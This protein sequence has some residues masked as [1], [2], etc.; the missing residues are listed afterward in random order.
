[1]KK[2]KSKLNFKCTAAVY[3]YECFITIYWAVVDTWYK[4]LQLLKI[5]CKWLINTVSSIIDKYY[6][7]DCYKAE[8]VGLLF[9]NSQITNKV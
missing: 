5:L 2:V 6:V 9:V 7:D 8:T 4:L 1:M 3:R